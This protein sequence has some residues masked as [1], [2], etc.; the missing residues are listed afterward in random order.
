[1]KS[2]FQSIKKRSYPNFTPARDNK[3]MRTSTKKVPGAPRKLK[4]TTAPAVNTP[5]WRLA[6]AMTVY[7]RFSP[8][9]GHDGDGLY[10]ALTNNSLKHLM[11]KLNVNG[12]RIVDIGAADGKVLLAGLA[13]GAVSAH[14][15]EVAGDALED[16]FDNMIT[17]LQRDGVLLTSQTARLKCKVNVAQLPT[18]CGNNMEGMLSHY[19]P[20]EFNISDSNSDSELIIIA[21]WHGFNVEAKQALLRCLCKSKTVSR[22]VVVGPQNFPY[23]KS[24]EI[25]EFMKDEKC[26]WKPKA[27]DKLVV[28]LSGGGETYRAN[29][30]AKIA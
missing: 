10:G 2:S 13:S 26:I 18:E 16:K 9:L 11:E 5:M 20:E 25:L 7:R 6:K 12:T 19:F 21:V 8:G 14:G 29:I 4:K 28:K 1:M 17:V 22:F 24:D 15:V 30:F 3:K 27:V 23:G